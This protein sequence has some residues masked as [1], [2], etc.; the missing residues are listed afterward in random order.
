MFQHM[1]ENL[2]AGFIATL[3]GGV[4]LLL[5]EYYLIIPHS[6]KVSEKEIKK[7]EE[8]QNPK[9]LS[10]N[11]TAKNIL[12][13]FSSAIKDRILGTWEVIRDH[14]DKKI[15][16]AE[17][18]QN[19]TVSFIWEIGEKCKANYRFIS[20]E[21]IEIK[22]ANLTYVFTLAKFRN[23]LNAYDAPFKFTKHKQLNVF[24]LLPSIP[25]ILTLVCLMS[26]KAYSEGVNFRWVLYFLLSLIVTAT[27][28][29]ISF[30]WEKSPFYGVINAGLS[31]F[32]VY[33]MVNDFRLK[34]FYI[35]NG[36]S[37]IVTLVLLSHVMMLFLSMPYLVD[38]SRIPK[39]IDPYEKM[40]PLVDPL[41]YPELFEKNSEKSAE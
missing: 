5:I 32:T 8:K 29:C 22:F 33:L 26:I 24:T 35:F 27:A 23:S 1:K 16:Q 37:W 15:A 31:Y 28:T 18:F 3:L 25:V 11:D 10:K 4:M 20:E 7:Q 2:I 12:D 38:S 30:S 21:N 40:C 39:R 9:Q 19:G 6:T 17:F 34:N 13:D 41:L 36:D 14:Q